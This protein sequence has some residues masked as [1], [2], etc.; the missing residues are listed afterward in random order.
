MS[1]QLVQTKNYLLFHWNTYTLIIRILIPQYPFTCL[2][3]VLACYSVTLITYHP[4]F[5]KITCSWNYS[6]AVPLLLTLIHHCS[7]SLPTYTAH[8]TQHTAHSTLLVSLV[9]IELSLWKFNASLPLLHKERNICIC[10]SDKNSQ[11]QTKV[12]TKKTIE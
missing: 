12:Q 10:P 9:I 6:S 8:S 7:L 11:S 3:M 1:K 2:C 4:I 5:P